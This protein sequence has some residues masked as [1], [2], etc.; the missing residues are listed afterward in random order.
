MFDYSHIL[1]QFTHPSFF[2]GGMNLGG[3]QNNLGP[4]NMQRWGEGS[5]GPPSWWQGHDPGSW[6]PGTPA[7][8]PGAGNAEGAPP[9]ATTT[10]NPSSGGQFDLSSLIHAL[11]GGQG[12]LSQMF[13]GGQMP[14]A[15]TLFRGMVDGSIQAP[16][17]Q[18]MFQNLLGAAQNGSASPGG[19][20]PNFDNLGNLAAHFMMGGNS[21]QPNTGRSDPASAGSPSSPSAFTQII[22]N[23]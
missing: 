20:K 10:Q 5:G 4:W 21:G 13:S 23:K 7:Q 18:N 12:N 3:Y 17:A 14:N 9:A 16:P 15:Q 1:G 2:G 11:T 22:G 8:A 19:M 6:N